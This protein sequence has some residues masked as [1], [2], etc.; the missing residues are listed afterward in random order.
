MAADLCIHVITPEFTEEDYK[1]F[2]ASTLGSKY[3]NPKDNDKDFN[4]LF[5][6]CSGTPQVWVG[7]VSW[8]KAALFDDAET[9]IPDPIDEIH[10]IIGE[11]FP[12]INDELIKKIREAIG[13]ENT[14]GYNLGSADDILK[15]LE[16]NK[17][18]KAFTIS[19]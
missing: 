2:Q 5:E 3:F 17:G 13:A 4:A 9:F 11:E 18:K 7:E 8:L 1:K 16:E 15:F 19:W 14:T 12:I 6:K 10:K